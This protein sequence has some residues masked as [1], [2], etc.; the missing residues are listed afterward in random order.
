M[1]APARSSRIPQGFNPIEAVSTCTQGRL[2]VNVEPG[3]KDPRDRMVVVHVDGPKDV[4]RFEIGTA[5]FEA[6]A[7]E[8]IA[9]TWGEVVD[10][11]SL[12]G[13]DRR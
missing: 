9:A 10:D 6:G 8:V 3:T 11:C 4:L 12:S 5:E 2:R 1:T 7:T 13:G